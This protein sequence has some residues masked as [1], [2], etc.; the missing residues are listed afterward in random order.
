MSLNGRNTHESCWIYTY[1]DYEI[2]HTNQVNT[3]RRQYYPRT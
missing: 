2:Y 1:G 3:R